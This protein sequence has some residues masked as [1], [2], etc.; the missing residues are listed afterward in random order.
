MRHFGFFAWLL[1]AALALQTGA[2]SAQFLDRLLPGRGESD[3]RFLTRTLQE[4]LS[5]SGREVQISGFRGALSSRATF[6]EM[7]IADDEGVW[8]TIEGGAMQWTRS[9]LL[10]RRIEIGE[11]SARRIT[12][13][14]PPVGDD[15]PPR[16]ELVRAPRI[17]L[18]ELPVAVDLGSLAIEEVILGEALL[19]QELR[20]AVTGRARLADGAGNADL[21]VERLDDVAG[22]FVIDGSFSNLTRE[23]RLHLEAEEDPGGLAVSLLDIPGAPSVALEITGEGP[24][25]TFGAD[26]RLATDGVDRVTG[27]FQLQ[28]SLP[29]VAQA[30]R[31]D[32]GGDLRPLLQPEFHPFFGS[33]SRLRTEAQRFEDGRLSLDELDIRTDKLALRGALAVGADNLPEFIDLRG[34][35]ASRDGSRVVLPVAGGGTS[36]EQAELR[37]GFDASVNEDWDLSLDML[38]FDNGDF[39][40]ESL[41]VEGLGRISTE[42]FGEDIDVV[43]ALIDFSALGLSARDQAVGEALGPAVTGSLALLWREGRPLLLPGFQLEGR[44][45]ALNGRA[46]LDDGVIDL[47]AQADFRNVARLSMLAGRPLSGAVQA[48]VDATLG[49][50][51]DRFQVAAELS[52]RDLTLD[53][54]ELDAL[55][56]GRS[57][58]S[59]DA[60]GADG[61]IELR[62]LEATARTLSADISGRVEGETLDLDGQLDFAD[63]SVLGGDFGG[64]MDAR[65]SLRGEIGAERLRLD[66][67]A[68]DLTVGQPDANRLLRGETRLDIAARRDGE[69]VDLQA[70]ELRNAA[71]RLTADGRFEA[72][73]SRLDADLRVPSLSALRPEY[74]GAIDGRL[75]VREEGADRRA[76]LDATAQGLRLGNA[77]ADSLLAGRYELSASV[78][79]RPEDIL[80]ERLNLSGPQV[81]ASVSG[82]LVDG[83]P[84]LQIDGRLADLALL[85]PGIT[86]PVTL[87]GTARGQ[88]DGYALDLSASGPAGV[89][90]SLEGTISD[91]LQANLRVQGRTD[92]ALI[93]PR[94]EPRSVQGPVSFQA[95]VNGPLALSSVQGSAEG[96]GLTVI[97]PQQNLRL[98]DIA[99]QARIAGGRAEL[100]ARGNSATGGSFTLGGDVRLE[101]QPQGDLRLQLNAL[102]IVDPQLFETEVSGGVAIRGALTRGPNI[103]GDLQLDRTEIRIPRVGLASRGYVPPGLRHSGD[104]AAARTTRDRAGIFAGET[105]GRERFP[106]SLDI[107]IDAPNRIFIRGRGLDAELGGDLRLTGTTADVI[108]IGQFGLIRGR[109]DLLGNRFTLNEGFASMQGDLVPFVRLVASTEREGVTARIVLEGPA[110]APEI[111]FESTPELPEEEVVALLLFG[112]GFESLSLFQAAQLAS[113]LAT[114][115]GRSEGMLERLRRN[116]GL[117]DLDVRTGTDGETTVRLGRYLTEQIYTD[118]E[119]SPQ[120]ASEVSINIDLTSS[121][122]ARG[123]IDSEGRAGVGLFFERDY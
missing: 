66:A 8:L 90:A 6:A 109:L 19:G 78:L 65:V 53:Q 114:L 104:S 86:G 54:A 99:L 43:D 7:T 64:A 57:V 94:I 3:E 61:A 88:A 123:R 22:R 30:V 108:P 48:R 49:P 17:E 102:R 77:V 115:S 101:D 62:R 29:G 45:Y 92:L 2:A 13:T 14:R 51:R 117:D 68:R 107:R 119:V 85:V 12:I 52:G 84:S 20:A 42:G 79:Q 40:V 67:L 81:N 23:L 122:T 63:L 21:Q 15:P 76:T 97:A 24:I 38:G 59:L 98:T 80:L 4:S 11:L 89:Q 46:R 87:G 95:T 111:L 121:L 39:Q 37:L 113:S 69:A 71:V 103:S 93:N 100:E 25:D 36:I 27:D 47:N 10:Q 33:E 35:I 70:L 9:A 110:T 82:Q 112:R 18:P 91:D 105:H 50:E 60:H 55:L 26:I 120:G 16:D 28:T 74:A 118:V 83:R 5:D 58:I 106:P 56:S 116:V 72:G 73:A 34:E 44:D 75:S 32:L 31:L 96:T 41:F 1:C